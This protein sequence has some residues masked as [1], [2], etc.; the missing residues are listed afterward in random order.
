MADRV[1]G[2]AYWRDHYEFNNA[3]DDEDSLWLSAMAG[4]G[5]TID[6]AELTASVT[7]PITLSGVRI[8]STT[9]DDVEQSGAGSI[10]RL[11]VSALRACWTKVRLLPAQ[12][13]LAHGSG[14]TPVDLGQCVGTGQFPSS[15]EQLPRGS[16]V[17]SEATL[18]F[19]VATTW[20]WRDSTC[21]SICC[22]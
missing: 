13:E 14:S 17:T 21:D 8:L 2:E 15:Q 9:R 7:K 6:E 19:V 16:A 3:Y 1:E 11:S 12:E 22:Y 10:G 5:S 18:L 20:I 4:I